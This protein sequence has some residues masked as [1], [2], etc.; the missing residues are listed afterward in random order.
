MVL[1]DAS[2]AS[3]ELVELLASSV[4]ALVDVLGSGV[5]VEAVALASEESVIERAVSVEL[6]ELLAIVEDVESVFDAATLLFCGLRSFAGADE[7]EADVAPE[8][9]A[10]AP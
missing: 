7:V 8:T 10:P 3:V 5:G 2:T 6:S 4:C 1:R 9:E